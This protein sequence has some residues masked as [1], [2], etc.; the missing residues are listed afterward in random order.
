MAAPDALA[1][2]LGAGGGLERMEPDRL[3]GELL[4]DGVLL[5]HD[6]FSSTLTRWRTACTMPRRDSESGRSTDLPM[7]RRPIERS[8][9]RWRPLVPFADFTW[10]ITS[11]LMP[12][13]PP[14]R[15]AAQPAPP[16]R[17]R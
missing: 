11:V 15:R 2:L 14:R 6:L 12:S 8:V 5:A 13:R 17:S 3:G 4:V 16:L 7:P 1:V 9:S 10:V